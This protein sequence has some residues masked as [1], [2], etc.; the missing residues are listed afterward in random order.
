MITGVKERLEDLIPEILTEEHKTALR[1]LKHQ[2]EYAEVCKETV[3][4]LMDEAWLEINY[5]KLKINYRDVNDEDIKRVEYG[6]A[7]MKR[8]IR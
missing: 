3:E 2:K 5:N 4:F 8:Y 7:L 6:I 1:E